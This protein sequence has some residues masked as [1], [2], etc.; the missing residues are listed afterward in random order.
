MEQQSKL[1][2]MR[3]LPIKKDSIDCRPY[4]LR[5]GLLISHKA[6]P[7]F[8]EFIKKYEVQLDH[9]FEMDNSLNHFACTGIY[10][11]ERLEGKILPTS[12][13]WKTLSYLHVEHYQQNVIPV[14]Y[15]FLTKLDD[16]EYRNQNM[17]YL[18]IEIGLSHN[19]VFVRGDYFDNP[20]EFG[21]KTTIW[22]HEQL[23]M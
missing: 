16:A 22:R 9:F 5:I 3:E 17:R 19:S 2:K 18:F 1:W 7:L 21:L 11:G 10:G 20:L 15:P 23:P 13:Y 4:P 6:R 8:N 12:Q 14:L